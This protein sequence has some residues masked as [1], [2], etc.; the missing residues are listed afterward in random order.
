M[1]LIINRRFLNKEFVQILF[2]VNEDLIECFS[3]PE[4]DTFFCCLKS[5]S[6][7]L[8]PF[9]IKVK[10]GFDRSNNCVLENAVDKTV[11]GYVQLHVTPTT[12]V[13]SD[14][15]DVVSIDGDLTFDNPFPEFVEK[16][17]TRLKASVLTRLKTIMVSME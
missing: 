11:R 16:A 17:V 2:K 5:I 12:F 4:P 9:F 8:P 7:F 1:G 3:E 6:D 14:L 10:V 15:G 13:V